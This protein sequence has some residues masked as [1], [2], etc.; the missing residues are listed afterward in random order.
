[1]NTYEYSQFETYILK[2]KLDQ[3]TFY[4]RETYQFGIINQEVQHMLLK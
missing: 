1:M 2:K 3:V 4:F